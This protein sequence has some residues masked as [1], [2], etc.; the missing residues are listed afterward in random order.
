MAKNVFT[1]IDYKFRWSGRDNRPPD[2]WTAAHR[3]RR[4]SVVMCS[5]RWGDAAFSGSRN[6][7]GIG[8]PIPSAI[9]LVTTACFY[10]S[11][12]QY[13]PGNYV[14]K[15]PPFLV[16]DGGPAAL[17]A[18]LD[19]FPIGDDVGDYA[20]YVVAH[21]LHDFSADLSSGTSQGWMAPAVRIDESWYEQ[22]LAPGETSPPGPYWK[23]PQPLYL[24]NF[25]LPN[26]GHILADY[27][28]ARYAWADGVVME[29]YA[30]PD[31][32]KNWN[33]CSWWLDGQTFAQ[34][35]ATY[36]T[37]V[38]PNGQTRRQFTDQYKSGM[39]DLVADLRAWRGNRIHFLGQHSPYQGGAYQANVGGFFRENSPNSWGN[40]ATNIANIQSHRA[41]VFAANPRRRFISLIHVWH[42]GGSGDPGPVNYY[43]ERLARNV[44]N[45]TERDSLMEYWKD[46]AVQTGA[47]MAIGDEDW[48]WEG[49]P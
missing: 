22:G 19:T 27:I 47:Y 31:W 25:R 24:I 48:L 37:H 34:R 36:E 2:L 41:A 3:A 43:D 6:P 8:K 30:T 23:L 46:I 40:K 42:P 4:L 14:Y 11:F 13:A 7:Y 33:D 20:R 29:Y 1:A 49:P 12:K 9:C 28:K 5:G 44:V 10:I 45:Q 26:A 39:N 18:D 38:L 17:G 21:G 32:Y 16:Q 15:D 35:D